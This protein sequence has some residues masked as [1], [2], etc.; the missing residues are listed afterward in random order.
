MKDWKNAMIVA[1]L[2]RVISSN[3]YYM[4]RA[5]KMSGEIQHYREMASAATMQR[6]RDFCESMIEMYLQRYIYYCKKK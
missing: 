6:Q 3:R 4:N 2:R 5:D 1:Y